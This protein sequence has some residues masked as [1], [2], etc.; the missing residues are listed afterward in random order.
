MSNG[1]GISHGTRAWRCTLLLISAAIC[2]F[3]ALAVLA[4]PSKAID[5]YYCKG[6][7][8]GYNWCGYVLVSS[9]FN[10]NHAYVPGASYGGVCEQVTLTNGLVGSYRC[11]NTDYATSDVSG[12]PGD[13]GGWYSKGY[14]M[15]AYAGNNQGLGQT[16]VGHALVYVCV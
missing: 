6:Y 8:Y 3:L 15:V 14:T 9:Q 5:D 1:E 12:C 10:V 11:S 16:I 2:A 13:L 4:P 7:V